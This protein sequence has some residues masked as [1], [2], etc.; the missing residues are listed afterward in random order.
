MNSLPTQQ[1][2]SGFRIRN[3]KCW[4]TTRGLTGQVWTEPETLSIKKS[5]NIGGEGAPRLALYC[6]DTTRYLD[7]ICSSLVLITPSLIPSHAGP[8]AGRIKEGEAGDESGGSAGG[9]GGGGGAG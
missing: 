2:L 4:I 1:V 6:E 9:G 3:L 7:V 8:G 5:N